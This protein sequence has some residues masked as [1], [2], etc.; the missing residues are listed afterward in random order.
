MNLGETCP[1]ATSSARKYTDED[2]CGVWGNDTDGEDAM[3]LGEN[4]PSELRPLEN[5]V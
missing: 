5:L 1:S 3:N 4:C 2:E